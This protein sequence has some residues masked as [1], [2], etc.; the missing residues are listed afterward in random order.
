MHAKR[1]RACVCAHARHL[2]TVCVWQC[3][4][5]V[6]GC[7]AM[8]HPR[9]TQR[10][11]TFKHCVH[12]DWRKTKRRNSRDRASVPPSQFPQ[13]CPSLTLWAQTHGHR[14][15]NIG[16]TAI[17]G[18]G[19]TTMSISVLVV[20]QIRWTSLKQQ[21]SRGRRR[22]QRGLVSGYVCYVFVRQTPSLSN[23]RTPEHITASLLC[24]SSDI[25]LCE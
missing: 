24:V 15:T 5:K 10:W 4:R 3:N 17:S 18:H 14:H 20:T 21:A 7:H 25:G 22:T 19:D 13:L 8:D 23:A 6:A 16:R 9:F 2:R 1:L 11:P 12:D